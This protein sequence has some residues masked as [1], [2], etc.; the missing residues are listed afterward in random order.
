MLAQSVSAALTH[1]CALFDCL[2]ATFLIFFFS[3]LPSSFSSPL[4]S[5]FSGVHA[6]WLP[7]VCGLPL[8]CLSQGIPI[9]TES[10]EQHIARLF[11]GTFWGRDKFAKAALRDVVM[12]VK[13]DESGASV[14]ARAAAM[15]KSAILERRRIIKR[16]APYMHWNAN[17][18]SNAM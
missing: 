18:E 2:P 3:P 5:S 15:E 11:G 10:C 13:N 16:L 1:G 17:N 8:F 9:I 7:C 14:L 12:V 6:A 4:P